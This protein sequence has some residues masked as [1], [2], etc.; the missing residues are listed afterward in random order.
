MFGPNVWM[1]KLNKLSIQ[2]VKINL[3]SINARLICVD[4]AALSR[5]TCLVS[6]EVMVK[7]KC[8]YRTVRLYLTLISFL[9]RSR[10]IH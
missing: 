2:I 8:V 10:P 6:R 7:S 1:K 4:Y 5:W 3:K 9:P